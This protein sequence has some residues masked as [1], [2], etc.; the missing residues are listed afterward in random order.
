MSVLL[1]NASFEPLHV[2]SLRRAVGLVVAGKVDVIAN[3]DGELHSASASWPIPT[4]LRLRYMV[5]VPFRRDIG[6]TRRGV[7]LRDQRRCQ[8]THCARAA[9]TL[10]HVV[11]RSRGGE[12]SWTNVVAACGPCN[13]RKGDRLLSELGWSLRHPPSMPRATVVMLSS[14]GVQRVPDEWAAWLPA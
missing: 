5:R 14:A 12:H 8:F 13:T 1:L 9:S 7:M 4:V 3:G 6:L 10:D 2:I 11:P